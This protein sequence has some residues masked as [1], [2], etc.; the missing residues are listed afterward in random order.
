MLKTENLKSI[1]QTVCGDDFVLEGIKHRLCLSLRLSR[2][3][4][5]ARGASRTRAQKAT[6]LVVVVAW[7]G[8]TR[9]IAT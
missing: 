1:D 3:G 8:K 2:D 9:I 7:D 6:R 4:G 5:V